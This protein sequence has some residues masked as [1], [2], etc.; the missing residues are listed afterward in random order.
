[1]TIHRSA[2]DELSLIAAQLG[3]VP[4]PPFRVA[5]RCVF[6]VPTTIVSPSRLSDGTPFP[7]YA[8]LTCPWIAEH[9]GSLESAGAIAQWSLRMADD[10]TLA[11][12]VSRTDVAVREARAVEGGGVD[13]CAHVGIAGQ[14]DPRHLKCLHAHVALSLAGIP[15]RI[16]SEVLGSIGEACDDGRCLGLAM[17]EAGGRRL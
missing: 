17:S 1:M 2:E 13:S 11:A 8:W 12:D 9:V 16:G 6:G 15:D 10:R 7:D 3:R 14:R 4:R 5:S